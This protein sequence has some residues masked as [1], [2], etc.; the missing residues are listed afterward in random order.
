MSEDT[1]GRQ[2]KVPS[3]DGSAESFQTYCEAALL[4]EP[5]TKFQDR[6]LA[7]PRLVGELQGAAKRLIVGQRPDWVSFNGGV[8]HLLQ[9]LRRCL[10]KPQVPELTDLLA[11]YFKTSKR[12]PGELMGEYITRKCELYVRA[13]QSMDR[14]KPH[15]DKIDPSP[16]ADWP[17][18]WNVPSRR[19]SMDSRAST[20]GATEAD[21]NQETQPAAPTAPTTAEPSD[22]ASNNA[23]TGPTDTWWRDW[24]WYGQGTYWNWQGNQNW[25]WQPQKWGTSSYGSSTGASSRLPELVPEF[26]Q[27]WLLLQDAGL[28]P[29]EKNTVI[30]ATQGDMSLQRVAQE[31]RNQFADADVKKKD[32]SRKYHGYV[33]D[34]LGESED[35]PPTAETSFNAE[36]ELTPE[37]LW[38]ENEEEIQ[39]A[40][41]TLQTTRRTL[42]EA[43]ER[44]KQVKQS[45]QY[46]RYGSKKGESYSQR[47]DRI[48]CLKCGKTGHKAAACPNSP[49]QASMV[50][51]APFICFAQ[52]ESMGEEAWAAHRGQD[53][54]TTSEA[55]ATGKAVIDCGATK[56]IGSV[57]ALERL[58]QLSQHGVSQVETADRPVFGF[59]NSSEDRCISTLHVKIRAAEK[60]GVMKIHALDQGAGPILLSV[61]TLKAL[62]AMIDFA[63][64]T[65]VLR[66]VSNQRL[67]FLEESQTGHL[68]LPLVDDLLAGAK[69]TRKPIPSL[70]SYLQTA[71]GQLHNQATKKGPDMSLDT[72]PESCQVSSAE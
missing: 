38:S 62:G 57:Q 25:N 7:G 29:H 36:T 44:Q 58:M 24:S 45:R 12:K 54:V 31:L 18:S 16:G 9:H 61:S 8:E 72:K 2:A 23:S 26:V 55:V 15:H 11:R 51:M 52:E 69:V 35:E 32:T 5:T 63:E 71:D 49:A 20:E 46:Y 3:W 40:L 53:R 28:E 67:L 1:G 68:L 39:N 41:A 60:P 65:M 42:R 47:E 66:H 33:G 59:G 19:S 43:R 27:A 64:G 37:A 70:S 14:I 13:Q 34:L 6:Y 10:G 17:G 4:Y 22:T 48:T 30:V 21:S 50:E 56:S